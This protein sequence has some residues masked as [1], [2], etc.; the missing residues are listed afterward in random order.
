MSSF[1]RQYVAAK[2][3]PCIGYCS[4]TYGDDYCRG[5]YRSAECVIL[6][7]AQSPQ[8]HDREY[9]RIA[10]LVKEHTQNLWKILDYQ[11]LSYAL[12]RHHVFFPHDK[13]LR[14]PYYELYQLMQYGLDPQQLYPEAVQWSQKIPEC[15][16]KL[17]KVIYDQMNQVEI[18]EEGIDS[19]G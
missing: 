14:C 3:N 15:A 8:E 13:S 12:E 9:L 5:C 19:C 16:K 17:A 11:L 2:S 1:D 7:T 10:G 4:T 6:W 18:K